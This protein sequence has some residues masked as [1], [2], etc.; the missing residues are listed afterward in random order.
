M[1]KVSHQD[2]NSVHKTGNL[3]HLCEEI[4]PNYHW[5]LTK[6]QLYSLSYPLQERWVAAPFCQS[7]VMT[8][9]M[10]VPYWSFVIFGYWLEIDSSLFL[11]IC[12]LL[13][14][15]IYLLLIIRVQ[16]ASNMSYHHQHG[17]WCLLSMTIV[18]SIFKL[19]SATCQ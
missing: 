16:V 4:S 7:D 18:R 6:G 12:C 9:L 17:C 13:S 10:S 19:S 8:N 5:V 15:T 11:F 3:V 14:V 2:P 1:P